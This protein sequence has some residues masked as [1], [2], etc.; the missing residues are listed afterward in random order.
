MAAIA[1]Q[2]LL[3]SVSNG[4]LTMH[5]TEIERRPYHRNCSCAMHKSTDMSCGG[6]SRKN[7]LL[8]PKN[9]QWKGGALSFVAPKSSNAHLL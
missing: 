3:R 2:F 1:A 8:L 6:C 7:T 4:C 9:Q 5:D